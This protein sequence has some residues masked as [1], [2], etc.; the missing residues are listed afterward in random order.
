MR[1]S[2]T[3]GSTRINDSLDYHTMLSLQSRYR[4]N[5]AF[6]FLLTPVGIFLQSMVDP[7]LADSDRDSAEGIDRILEAGEI[8]SSTVRIGSYVV[9]I[10]GQG[11]RNPVSGEWERLE[12]ARGYVRAVDKEILTLARGRDGWQERIALDRIQTLVLV[13]S[14]SR[15][16]GRRLLGQESDGLPATADSDRADAIPDTNIVKTDAEGGT[17][18]RIKIKLFSSIVG[19]NI[20]LGAGFLTGVGIDDYY[21]KCRGWFATNEQH[22]SEDGLCVDIGA[23][24]GA[25]TGWILGA[26]IGVS[27]VEPDD[28]FMHTLAGSLGGMLVCGLLTLVS[29]GTLWPSLMVGP[30]VF[31]IIASEWSRTAE[32]SRESLED[33]G[34][35]HPFSL[36]LMPILGGDF[37]AVV[38]V[39]F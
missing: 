37:A 8:D 28:R 14:Q 30:T 35:E 25:S 15:G 7:V 6:R 1:S 16:V 12:T 39:R 5:L 4:M 31:P 18:R 38:T 2:P 23:A 36:G 20:F 3:P 13:G 10:H 26:P 27:M 9:V 11:E 33:L 19:S 24:I 34:E 17:S 32:L 29:D 21:G 22:I